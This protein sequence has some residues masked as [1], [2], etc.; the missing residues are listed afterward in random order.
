MNLQHQAKRKLKTYSG[1]MKQRIGIAQALIGDPK[2]L[3]VDE[4]TTG[5]GGADTIS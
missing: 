1:R 4:P 2:V 5:P 3:V